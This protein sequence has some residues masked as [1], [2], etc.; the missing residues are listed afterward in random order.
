MEERDMF[1]SSPGRRIGWKGASA[2]AMFLV[3]CSESTTNITP[4]FRVPPDFAFVTATDFATGSAALVAADTTLE[5]YCN[6]TAIHSDAVARYFDGRIYIVNRNGADNIQVLEPASGFAT[7]KQFSVGNGSDPHD[8]AFVSRTRAFVTRYNESQLWIVDTN[9]GRRS[10]LIDFTWLA[11]ADGIPEMDHMVR[12]G[13][14]I[15]V[16]IQRLNRDTDWGPVGASYIAVF[17][18]FTEQ[19][20]DTDP[21][22]AGTQALRMVA[23]NPFGEMVMN[24]KTPVIWV[25]A[26]GR[27]G[28]LDGGLEIVNPATLESQLVLTES[29][30]GGD[31]SDVVPIDENRGV[32]IVS[33]ANF[34]SMLVG[35]DLSVSGPVDTL[36]APGGFVLQDAELSRDQRIFVSDRTVV[37]P[38]IRVFTSDTWTQI[39]NT[40]IDVCLPP[41]DIEFGRR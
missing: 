22:T 18:A 31:I 41:A 39:T 25:P 13:D 19:F 34:N 11:D 36:Y 8:I 9:Q 29:Q 32:A 30:L 17:N 40:P 3:A 10:G 20:V 1:S 14:Y 5:R 37:R 4:P 33:D 27:F 28:I 12:V 6:L 26:A 24:P 35:F 16:S 21:V 15:F 23:T 38:G 7:I 2:A